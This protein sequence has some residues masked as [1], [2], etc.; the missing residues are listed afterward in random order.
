VLLLRKSKKSTWGKT[1][2]SIIAAKQQKL[3]QVKSKAI[4]LPLLGYGKDTDYLLFI[5]LQCRGF[6]MGILVQDQ[7][8]V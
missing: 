6:C 8:K 4:I 2:T 5:K 3:T 1:Q 7:Y